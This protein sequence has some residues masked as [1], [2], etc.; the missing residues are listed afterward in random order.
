MSTMNSICLFDL[1]PDIEELITQELD[2]LLGFRKA[3]KHFKDLI[4]Y[5]KNN[6]KRMD[7]ILQKL[8]GRQHQNKYLAMVTSGTQTRIHTPNIQLNPS[9]YGFIYSSSMH[10]SWHN[11]VGVGYRIH[12]SHHGELEA[13]VAQLN[14]KLTELGATKFKSK[15]KSAKIKLL[16]SY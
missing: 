4:K 14:D 1:A 16:M 12:Y 11:W 6:L 2:V 13:T 5:N 7:T 10:Q 15:D 3:T 8:M 9:I